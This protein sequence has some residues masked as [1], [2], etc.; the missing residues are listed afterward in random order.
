MSLNLDHIAIVIPSYNEGS[1][2]LKVVS[3]VQ[4]KGYQNIIVVD[5]GSTDDSM[6]L[7]NGM[8]VIILQHLVN[9]G[10]GAAT[11]TGL[12]YCRTFLDSETVVM[13]DADTQHDVEDISKLIEAHD[14]QN[15]DITI[16]N[17]FLENKKN[18]PVKNWLYN[19]I[20]NIVTS[21][22]AGQIVH[23]S[24]SGFKVFNNKALH[25]IIIEQDKYEHCSE[26]LIKGLEKKLK[27]IEV[28]IQVYYTPETMAKG[29][30]F[31]SGIRTFV[32][33][34]YSVLFKRH[35]K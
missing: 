33:L 2:L 1:R 16:G 9:R 12:S 8:N 32:H 30:H 13:I 10:A 35:Q 4:N 20:A 23:D 31:L 11:E 34:L 3:A 26:I 21:I 6:G 25:Q 29:Q 19:Q 24:Q 18:M 7:I 14:K 27:I 5:D 22:F 17:R 28:P 15:A